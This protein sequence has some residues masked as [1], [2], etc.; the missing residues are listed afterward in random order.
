M[1]AISTQAHSKC[2]SVTLTRKMQH[3]SLF[4]RLSSFEFWKMNW[5]GRSSQPVCNITRLKIKKCEIYTMI[6]SGIL[7]GDQN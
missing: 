5:N 4:E 1:K 7:L 2:D 6:Y 3:L